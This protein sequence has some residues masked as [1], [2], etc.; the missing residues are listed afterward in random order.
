MLSWC[1]VT[2]GTLLVHCISTHES[3]DTHVTADCMPLTS[4]HW[5][6]KLCGTASC[7]LWVMLLL[8]S[9]TKC[10]IRVYFVFTLCKLRK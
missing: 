6:R 3:R 2:P 4:N 9:N 1:H 7:L 10:I 5:Y 8:Q